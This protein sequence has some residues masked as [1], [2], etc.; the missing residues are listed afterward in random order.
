MNG[1]DCPVLAP[2]PFPHHQAYSSP[3]DASGGRFRISREGSPCDLPL[4]RPAYE[5]NENCVNL[6]DAAFEVVKERNKRLVDVDP[7][8]LRQTDRGVNLA[9]ASGRFPLPMN[10]GLPC[11]RTAVPRAGVARTVQVSGDAHRTTLL[12]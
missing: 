8:S 10:L 12:S 6:F 9:R 2:H 4:P 5:P 7:L 3:A 1:I 11:P